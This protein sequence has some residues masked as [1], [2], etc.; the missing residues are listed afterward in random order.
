MDAFAN[1]LLFREKREKKRLKRGVLKEYKKRRKK[2]RSRIPVSITYRSVVRDKEARCFLSIYSA[3][4][5]AD[6][7]VLK[8]YEFPSFFLLLRKYS[9][10][11]KHKKKRARAI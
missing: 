7:N 10:E 8:F 5:K 3:I 6:S 1:N 11:K 2:R 4:E 9:R